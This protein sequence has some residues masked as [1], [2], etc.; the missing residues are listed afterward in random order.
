[1][2]RNRQIGPSASA[3]PVARA[4]PP[5]TA[6]VQAEYRAMLDQDL[7]PSVF[8]RGPSRDDGRP[9]GLIRLM[10]RPAGLFLLALTTMFAVLGVKLWREGVFESFRVSHVATVQTVD[11]SWM[12][13]DRLPRPPSEKV[14]ETGHS[15]SK[16]APPAAS[17]TDDT[18]SG[19]DTPE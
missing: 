7:G 10:F 5:S 6:Q 9:V 16:Q 12:L 13:G 11:K 3:A 18:V 4:A 14:T 2:A 17:E 1:M 19:D 8:N 15:V